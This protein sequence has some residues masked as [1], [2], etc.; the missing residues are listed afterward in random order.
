MLATGVSGSLVAVVPAVPVLDPTAPGAVD[1]ASVVVVDPVAGVAAE[2][3][4]GSP[5]VSSV[6]PAASAATVDSGVVPC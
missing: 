3:A 1:A 4:A 5:F 2:D 6:K